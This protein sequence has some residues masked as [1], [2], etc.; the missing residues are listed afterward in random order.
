MKHIN[1]ALFAVHLGC[2]HKCTFCDQK[3]ISGCQKR[4]CPEDVHKAVETALSGKTD[5]S[6]GEIAF[7]GGSFTLIEREEMISLLAAAKE[8]L[9]RGEAAGIR[10]STRPDGI[11]DEIC[12]ILKEYGVTAVELGAQSMDDEVLKA[13]RRGHTAKQVEAACETLKRHGFEL[14]LQMMTGLY[15]ST[16]ADSIETAKKIIE[17][18][19][20][21]VRIYP[22]VV[23]KNTEL[24]R[25]AEN[26]LYTPQ[27][28]EQAAELGSILIPMFEQ[29]GIKII[30]FGLH[31]GGGVEGENLGGAWHPALRE[32]AESRIFYNKILEEAHG[33]TGNVTVFVAPAAVSKA[34]GQKRANISALAEKGLSCTVKPLSSLSGRQ[35]IL[36]FT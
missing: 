15:R 5:V 7:F 10:I 1:I 35:I 25:L 8:H 32:L 28:P 30:R 34:T 11:D 18:K 31:S 13:N 27:T 24:A 26:G 36:E 16:D 19:P 6:G 14:G 4:L 12:R 33:K 3:S 23:M 17:L 20:A 22:T 21:T 9:D 2:P 29:A